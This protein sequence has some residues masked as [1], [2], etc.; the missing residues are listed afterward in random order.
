M[1]DKGEVEERGVEGKGK[2]LV[3][4]VEGGRLWREVV[5][6]GGEWPQEVRTC[7]ILIRKD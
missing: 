4:E 3:E 7:T 5:D 1:E 2:G 6:R